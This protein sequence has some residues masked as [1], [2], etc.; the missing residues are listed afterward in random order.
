MLWAKGSAHLD[1]GLDSYI[2]SA[3]VLADAGASVA[4][5]QFGLQ[6]LAC[7]MPTSPGPVRRGALQVAAADVVA[8]PVGDRAMRFDITR[9]GLAPATR[10]PGWCDCAFRKHRT[11]PAGT[12]AQASISVVGDLQLAW[13]NKTDKAKVGGD[14]PVQVKVVHKDG[15]PVATSP[16]Q[17][18]VEVSYD[19]GANGVTRLKQGSLAD[20]VKGTTVALK[21][22]DGKPLAPG[23]GKLVLT[24]EGGHDCQALTKLDPAVSTYPLTIITPVNYPVVSQ[25]PLVLKGNKAQRPKVSLPRPGRSR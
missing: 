5:L 14:L 1:F 24:P 21:T 20:F 13:V 2:T 22:K 17:A 3:S 6:A 19:A 25:T 10:A 4:G 15:K 23:D 18:N 8:T 11:S 16:P 12:F 7:L 9:K